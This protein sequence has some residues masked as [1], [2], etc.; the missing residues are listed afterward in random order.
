MSTSA[1][2]PVDAKLTVTDSEMFTWFDVFLRADRGFL[3]FTATALAY[4]TKAKLLTS[5]G[6]PPPQLP[7]PS[8]TAD[9]N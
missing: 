1:L 5:A 8:S 6:A 3:P 4:S 7:T 9:S 2:L